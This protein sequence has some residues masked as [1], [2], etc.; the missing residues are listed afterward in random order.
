MKGKNKERMKLG[1][2]RPEYLQSSSTKCQA[3]GC[4]NKIVAKQ[5]CAK[6]VA[7]S[8]KASHEHMES[9]FISE[10]YRYRYIVTYFYIINPQFREFIY[11][12][13]V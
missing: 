13:K 8:E 10:G 5:S 3:D 1:W 2:P 9:T 6:I 11:Q 12:N 4:P 7:D